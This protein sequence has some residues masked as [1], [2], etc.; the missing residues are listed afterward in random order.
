MRQKYLYIFQLKWGNDKGKYSWEC[1]DDDDG[2]VNICSYGTPKNGEWKS[3]LI[4]AK[5][6]AKGRHKVDL[7][8]KRES[9]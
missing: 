7:D 8:A 1:V 4:A 9:L 6:H 2:D 5:A 3:A